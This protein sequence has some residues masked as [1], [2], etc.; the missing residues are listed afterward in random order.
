MG[1]PA[2]RRAITDIPV[3]VEYDARGGIRKVKTFA[4]S[5]LARAFYLRK[6]REGKNPKIVC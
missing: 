4:N 5:L 3:S 2:D 1:F 6:Y